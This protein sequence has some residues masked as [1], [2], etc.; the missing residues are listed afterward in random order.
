MKPDSLRIIFA[1]LSRG[2]EKTGIRTREML[3]VRS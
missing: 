2:L 1:G 3:P